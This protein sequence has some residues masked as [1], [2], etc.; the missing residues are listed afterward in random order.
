MRGW[1]TQ[2][3]KLNVRVAKSDRE[4]FSNLKI[5]IVNIKDSIM[6]KR[7]VNSKPLTKQEKISL[8]EE[9]NKWY[10]DKIKEIDISILN[11]K[12]PREVFE[13]I[14]DK[15]GTWLVNE[16]KQTSKEGVVKQFL[17]DNPLPPHMKDLLPDDFRA[18]SLLLNGLKQWISAES[19]ATDRY[20]LGGTARDTCRNISVKCIVTNK[21]LGE[22]PELHHPLRDGRPPI[23]LSKIGHDLIENQQTNSSDDGDDMWSKIKNIRTKK[24]MSWV[25]LREGCNA[26]MGTANC[27]AGAKSFAKTIMKETGLSPEKIIE[28]LNSKS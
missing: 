16:A 3:T 12:I 28:M 21:S 15:I 23:L 13:P 22:K 27:R 1:V 4:I 20:L 18:F 10:E 24:H 25:Q 7:F 2:A 8:L 19:A 11:V 17:D 14:L 26:L 9:Y 6:Y 5:V